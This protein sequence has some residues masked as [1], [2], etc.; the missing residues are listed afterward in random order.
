M[1]GRNTPASAFTAH[2]IEA[3]I[4]ASI[5]TVGDAYDNALMESQIGLY[6]TELI[7]RTRPVEEASPKSSWPP[8]SGSTG[9]TPPGCTLPSGTSRLPSTKPTT[10]L[11]TS[12]TGCWSQHLK[13]PRNPG[14]FKWPGES[15]PACTN[16]S[17][18]LIP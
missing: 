6:K 15:G 13:P 9:S 7:K 12:P 10:T 1:P 17:D 8:P 3:G 5:G 4:D 18:Q 11:K 2:L 16:H 14:R